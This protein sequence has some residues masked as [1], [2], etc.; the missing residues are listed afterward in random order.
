[1]LLFSSCDTNLPSVKNKSTWALAALA[2]E[3]VLV[4]CTCIFL[5]HY[6]IQ[7]LDIDPLWWVVPVVVAIISAVL[8]LKEVQRRLNS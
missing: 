7:A 8:L 1:M 2:V 5:G 4:P 3:S 6:V